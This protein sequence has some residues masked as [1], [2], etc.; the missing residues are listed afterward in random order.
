M[1]IK[2][3]QREV[4]VWVSGDPVQKQASFHAETVIP[5]ISE[6]A[7]EIVWTRGGLFLKGKEPGLHA[8]TVNGEAWASILYLTETGR[9]DTVRI[10]K[11]IEI[12][13]DAETSDSEA[14]PQL[15]WYLLGVQGKLL[16]P[17]KLGV[18]FEVKATLRSFMRG[19]ALVETVL[20]EDIGMRLHTLKSRNSALTITSVSEKSFTLREQVSPTGGNSAL[21]KIDAEELRFDGLRTEQI[22]N[23]CIVKGNMKLLVWGRDS[24]GMPAKEDHVIPFSQLLDCSEEPLEQ[25]SVWIEPTSLY[26]ERAEESE[27][28]RSLD[29]EV[30]AVLQLCAYSRQDVVTICD[31]YSSMMPLT[32]EVCSKTLLVA[33]EPGEG[34]LRAD[35][36]LPVPDDMAALLSAEAKLGAL[37]RKDV[38]PRIPLYLDL[39][40]R[41]SDGSLAAARRTMRLDA[42]DIPGDA[43][44]LSANV[45]WITAEEVEKGIHL[46]AEA[47]LLWENAKKETVST[48]ALLRLEEESAWSRTE[49]PSVSLVRRG[50]DSLWE[51]AKEY[52]SSVEL[53]QAVNEENAEFLLVPAEN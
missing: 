53:I 27:G 52:R 13:F 33:V 12:V 22:G 48:A 1:E 9:L 7:A 21:Q 28:D 38:D 34:H 24:A 3:L 36:S 51:L 23:R 39:F 50:G 6:D 16:N 45:L 43:D 19:E 30:H 17:R 29:V 41:R 46:Q 26:L 37:E 15:N 25:S 20:P 14:L 44:I 49:S 18:T 35:G 47:E 4:P 11:E 40:Y 10:Q 8:V 32:M 31:A 5:D 2:L 42:S